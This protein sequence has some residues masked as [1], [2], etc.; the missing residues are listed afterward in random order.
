MTQLE[1]RLNPLPD[2]S[3]HVL[4]FHE[5]TLASTNFVL[6]MQHKVGRS[7]HGPD[8]CAKSERGLS[9]NRS[10]ELQFGAALSVRK[11]SIVPNGSSALHSFGSW[12]RCPVARPGGLHMSRPL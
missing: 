11:A 5:P 9:L 10:A 7:V 8:A 4:P 1:A 3:E 2:P 12:P 6:H